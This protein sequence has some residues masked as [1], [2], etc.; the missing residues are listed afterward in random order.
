M[1]SS[2]C[3]NNPRGTITSAIWKVIE[4]PWRTIFAPTFTSRPHSIVMKGRSAF[5]LQ[6]IPPNRPSA[7]PTPSETPAAARAPRAPPA[8][9]R[10]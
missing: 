2:I 5:T 8:A 6:M 10:P 7:P 3:W 4:R 1:A 9:G